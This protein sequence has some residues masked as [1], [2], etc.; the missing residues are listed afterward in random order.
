MKKMLIMSLLVNAF[1][2]VA[3]SSYQ[4][5]EIAKQIGKSLLIKQ[6]SLE[7]RKNNKVIL[8]RISFYTLSAQETDKD[9]FT[10]SCGEI[11]KVKETIIALSRDLFFSNGKKIC[12]KK[13]KLYLSNETLIEGIVYDTTN[14]RYTKTADILVSSRKEAFL[15]GVQKGYLQFLD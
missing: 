15:L 10:A 7:E 1:V 2:V 8:N 3:P 12:G 6:K 13:I 4:S 14:A 9:P 5:L 11:K